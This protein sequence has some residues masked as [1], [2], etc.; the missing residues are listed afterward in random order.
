[1]VSLQRFEELTRE[2]LDSLPEWVLQRME[3]VEVMVEDEAPG[4]SRTLLGRYEGIPLTR[5]NA[6][7]SGV[8]PDRIAL[9]RF[10]LERV[11]GQSE[12]ALRT[13]ISHTVAHEVAHYFGISDDRLREIGQ[14]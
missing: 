10:N 9:Y 14:Y 4:G 2:A 6:G 12:E 5:R 11:S 7:Y 3:N 8:M 1:M 13:R